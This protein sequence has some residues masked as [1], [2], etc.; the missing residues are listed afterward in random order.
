MRAFI[1]LLVI[2]S[3]I[4]SCGPKVLYDQ[5]IQ[6]PQPWMYKDTL[7]FDY[8]IKDISKPYDLILSVEYREDFSYENVYLQVTTIFPD[9]VRTTY[10]VSLQLADEKGYWQGD[11]SGNKC[12]LNISM[13]SAAYYKKEGKYSLLFEQY[14]R[15]DSLKGIEALTISIVEAEQ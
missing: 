7:N 9:T 14:S 13:S 8:E 12:K 15:Q 3:C 2:S 6:V 11:C 5:T 1:L 10:P 4:L